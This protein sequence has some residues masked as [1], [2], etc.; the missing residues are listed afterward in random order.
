[1]LAPRMPQSIETW[2]LTL[3]TIAWSLLIIVFSFLA[4]YD[5]RWLWLVSLMI[6]FQ[7]ITDLMDGA[8]GRL[9]NTGLVKWG[10]Y[11]DHF[12]DYLFLCSILIGYAMLLEDHNKYML[13]FVLALF[14]AFM[15]NSFLSFSATGEF[16]IS[17][18]G[19][20]PTEV[21]IVFIVINTLIILFGQTH[22]ARAL[23][24]VLVLSTFGLF[25]TVYRTQKRIW[26]IDMNN[27]E[28]S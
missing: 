24:Y 17:Y 8:V 6:F 28:E 26:D 3:S 11:M 5:T 2:H 25:I 12:L 1:W 23:P 22:I 18:L 10:Y 21:R 15:V 27:K 19:I 7:Y 20:G 13:F 16:K 4:R 14:G 9:R